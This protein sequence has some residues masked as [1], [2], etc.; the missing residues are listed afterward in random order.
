MPIDFIGIKDLQIPIQLNS[1]YTLPARVSIFVSLDDPQIRGV[2]ISRMCLDI[3]KYFA[4]KSLKIVDLKQLVKQTIKNQKGLSSRGKIR[5]VLDW[6]D[7]KKALLSDF[8]GWRVYPFFVEVEYDEKTKKCKFIVGS[9]VTYSSTCPC[10]ASLSR[11]VIKQDFEN[12]FSKQSKNK[13]ISKEQALKWFQDESFLGATPH[14]QKSH[15]EFKLKLKESQ[16]SKFSVLKC[17]NS[18]EKDLG[19]AVQTIVKREDEAEFARLNAQNLMFCEDAVRRIATNLNKR[20]D[21]EGYSVKVK[22]YESLHPFTVES[23]ISKGFD[24]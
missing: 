23:T 1:K 2:H 5:V 17:L 20:K 15:A 19:T 14:A 18:L 16:V 4:K 8:V 12:Y 9:T 6:P 13:K 10:S 21:I 11:E 7:Q 22:H 3:H 24:E